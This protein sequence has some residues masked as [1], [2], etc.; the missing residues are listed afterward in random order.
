[1]LQSPVKATQMPLTESI[2]YLLLGFQQQQK[3]MSGAKQIHTL[4]TNAFAQN[5]LQLTCQQ[6][7]LLT[8]C[9]IVMKI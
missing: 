4:T 9:N 3:E 1:M 6:K 5:K 8:A 7:Q 2:S